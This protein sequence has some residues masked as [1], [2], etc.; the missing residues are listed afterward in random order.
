LIIV[1]LGRIAD[2]KDRHDVYDDLTQYLDKSATLIDPG[3]SDLEDEDTEEEE[4]DESASEDESECEIAPPAH[5]PFRMKWRT[6][7]RSPLTRSQR[8]RVP[9]EA[10]QKKH[11]YY[12]DHPVLRREWEKLVRADKLVW[13]ADNYGQEMALKMQRMEERSS[14]ARNPG[15]DSD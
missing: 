5:V 9:A 4:E 3:D 8:A 10:L 14:N 1:N 12:A 15:E 2:D 11:R 7:L 6:F 13:I